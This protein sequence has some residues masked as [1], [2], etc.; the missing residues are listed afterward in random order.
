MPSK[1]KPLKKR[2]KP[3]QFYCV[4]CRK[5]TSSTSENIKVGYFKNYK[6]PS[7]KVPVLKS[8]CSKCNCKVSKFVKRDKVESL[9][10]KFN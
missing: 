3:N 9:K 7:G 4:S 10:K 5:P 8:N 6:A 2:L 1:P